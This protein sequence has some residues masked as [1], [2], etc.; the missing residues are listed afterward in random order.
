MRVDRQSNQVVLRSSVHAHPSLVF[1]ADALNLAH[2]SH[3]LIVP[4]DQPELSPA[5]RALIILLPHTFLAA[6]CTRDA[7]LPV[8]ELV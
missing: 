8:F 5:R 4:F 6:V 1:L 2:P 7:I 3:I